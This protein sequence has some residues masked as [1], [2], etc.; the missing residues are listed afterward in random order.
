MGL[1]NRDYGIILGAFALLLI[2][3]TVSMILE[4][5]IKVEAVV[6]LINVLVIFASL[7]FVYKGVNLV[8]GEIGRA[9]SIAAVGI[10]Y[11]GI[12]I[13]PHLYYHIASPEMIGPFGAD[14]V[15]IFLHTST[16]LTFFVIAWGF[17]QLYESGKE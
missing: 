11:Y 7:Y 17:Y 6:D 3:S 14:S 10:G 13:L 8:G 15:E 4:L 16:T 2:V 1:E 5:P 12:Y 9:M